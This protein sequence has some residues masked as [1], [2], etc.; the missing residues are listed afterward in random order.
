MGLGFA[1]ASLLDIYFS[2]SPLPVPMSTQQTISMSKCTH[3]LVLF[4]ATQ[5]LATCQHPRF[6]GDFVE[7]L[8][9]TV[10][11]VSVCVLHGEFTAKFQMKRSHSAL[12]DRCRQQSYRQQ[13][14]VPDCANSMPLE[15][16]FGSFCAKRDMC[17]WNVALVL[18]DLEAHVTAGEVAPLALSFISKQCCVA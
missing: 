7:V 11:A 8:G 2:R 5:Y 1:V 9:D 16:W 15:F 12:S 3:F 18:I 13:A 6:G 17:M 4:K 10:Q 14:P